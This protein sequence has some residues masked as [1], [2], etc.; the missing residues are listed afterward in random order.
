[1]ADVNLGKVAKALED[2][3]YV[4]VGFGVL[5]F[6][7]GQVYRLSMQRQIGQAATSANRK[8]GEVTEQVV[9][10]FPIEAKDLVEAVSDFLHD[11][12]Q[13]AS[14]ILKEALA[15]GRFAL[16]VV[17]APVDRRTYP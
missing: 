15:L 13:E 17:Q 8:A 9:Q 4:A 14:D 10:R 12:P 3:A 16:R 11:L 2:P 6:Q 5:G 7:R 1:M